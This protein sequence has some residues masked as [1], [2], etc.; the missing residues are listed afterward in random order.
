MPRKTPLVGGK[1]Y[2]TIGYQVVSTGQRQL[3]LLSTGLLFGPT[4]GG[5][6]IRFDMHI[7]NGEPRYGGAM[8]FTF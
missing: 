2:P 4:G 8:A 6:G 7:V 3:N 1:W 5:Q